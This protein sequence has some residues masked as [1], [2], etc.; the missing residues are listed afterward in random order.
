MSVADRLNEWGKACRGESERLNYPSV[1]TIQTMIE[2]VRREDRLAR[3][4]RR[5]RLREPSANGRESKTARKP[6]P[7]IGSSILEV[8]RIVASLP[9]WMRETLVRRYLWNQP[10][11]IAAN[12]L[13]LAKS[14]YR[15]WAEAAEEAVADR[16]T[17]R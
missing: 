2:H 1:S 15:Q 13:R 7:V 10:D 6:M 9:Q 14:T 12:C 17:D 5:S 4:V 3:G 11:R 16:L 8:D